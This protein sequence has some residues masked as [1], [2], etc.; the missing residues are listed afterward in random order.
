MK[1]KGPPLDLEKKMNPQEEVEKVKVQ[2]LIQ[3]YEQLSLFIDSIHTWYVQLYT[4]LDVMVRKHRIPL[5]GSLTDA[6]PKNQV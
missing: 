5:V 3:N 4:S 6:K 2:M 1:Y